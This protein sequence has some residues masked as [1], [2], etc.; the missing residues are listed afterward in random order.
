M[1]KRLL[2][3]LFLAVLVAS[4]WVPAAPPNPTL[5]SAVVEKQVTKLTRKVH[6][7]DS[8]EEAREK[9][10]KENKLLARINGT[11]PPFRSHPYLDRKTNMPRLCR[12][13]APV[14]QREA[15]R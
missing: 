8:L 6:W 7:Y 14:R 10:K 9:A 5:P 2:A 1:S 15:A 11:A 13:T 12:E 4:S 3:G